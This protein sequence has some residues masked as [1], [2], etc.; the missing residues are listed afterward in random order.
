MANWRIFDEHGVE[1]P[2]QWEPVDVGEFVKIW[3]F[4]HMKPYSPTHMAVRM[5]KYWRVFPVYCGRVSGLSQMDLIS[6]WRPTERTG[7]LHFD[8][9][10][11]VRAYLR[12]KGSS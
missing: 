11:A 9:I 7:G 10:D 6:F 3:A 1:V 12:L 2:T 8:T 5:P 4:V